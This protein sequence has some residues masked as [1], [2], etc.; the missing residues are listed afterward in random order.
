MILVGED[1]GLLAIGPLIVGLTGANR[2]QKD[3]GG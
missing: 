3:P 1:C 2:E